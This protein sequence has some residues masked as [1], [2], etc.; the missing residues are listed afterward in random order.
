MGHYHSVSVDPWTTT[1]TANASGVASGSFS[2]DAVYNAAEVDGHVIVLHAADGT[3]VACGVLGAVPSTEVSTYPGYDG[4]VAASGFVVVT[5]DVGACTSDEASLTVHY[6][7]GGLE[8]GVGTTGGLHIHAGTG[9]DAAGAHYY[10]SQLFSEDPWT[11]TYNT[12][13]AEGT[14]FGS[15]SVGS[16]YDI[17]EVADRTVVVHA[18]SGDRASCGEL[19]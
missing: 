8:S 11:T 2:V 9:C 4:S 7:L 1:Y 12:T 19:T 17:S 10:D 16:G 18:S 14:A 15:F 13:D 6:M 5:Q 3:R